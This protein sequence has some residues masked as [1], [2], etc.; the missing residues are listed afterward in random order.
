M[1]MGKN[2]KEVKLF[3]RQATDEEQIKSNINDRE[4]HLLGV[5]MWDL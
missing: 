4:T 1:I 2:P 5:S 3:L